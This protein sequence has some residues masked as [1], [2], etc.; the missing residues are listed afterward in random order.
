VESVFIQRKDVLWNLVPLPIVAGLFK[1]EG[2]KS[3]DQKKKG[4]KLNDVK[5]RG[6]E[7]IPTFPD[8]ALVSR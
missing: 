1:T 4:N 5:K 8:L 7:E 2:E 6:T 3:A